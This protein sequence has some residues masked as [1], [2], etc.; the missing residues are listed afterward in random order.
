MRLGGF[1][2]ALA[3]RMSCDGML[4]SARTV[5]SVKLAAVSPPITRFQHQV[6]MVLTIFLFGQMQLSALGAWPD[7]VLKHKCT[8]SDY[9][10]TI[11]HTAVKYRWHL[12]M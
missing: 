5:L 3:A 8:E 1:W 6:M 4:I 9:T 2:R 7:V 10:H 12:Q 11:T